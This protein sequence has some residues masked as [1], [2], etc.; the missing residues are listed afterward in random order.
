MTRKEAIS[1]DPSRLMAYQEALAIFGEKFMPAPNEK[2]WFAAD[3]P[4]H[5]VG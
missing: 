2:R 1:N 3:V 5:H 4:K